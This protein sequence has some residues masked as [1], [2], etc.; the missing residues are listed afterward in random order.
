MEDSGLER[1]VLHKLTRPSQHSQEDR[2][3]VATTVATWHSP[4]SPHSHPIPTYSHPSPP[5][6]PPHSQPSP[7][8]FPILQ[9]AILLTTYSEFIRPDKP[10]ANIW[11]W[12]SHCVPGCLIMLALCAH[13]RIYHHTTSCAWYSKPRVGAS[14]IRPLSRLQIIFNSLADIHG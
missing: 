9:S 12:D 13:H 2:V 11:A 14:L 7:D 4:S 5:Q 1:V 10:K 3:Y 6:V 8:A